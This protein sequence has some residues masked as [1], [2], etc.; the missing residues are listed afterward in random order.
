VDSSLKN[1]SA[2]QCLHELN[3]F[4]MNDGRLHY[5]KSDISRLFSTMRAQSAGAAAVPC[6]LP[7]YPPASCCV[8]GVI[9]QQCCMSRLQASHHQPLLGDR[10]KKRKKEGVLTVFEPA[11]SVI[12]GPCGSTGN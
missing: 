11:R 8:R 9:Q 1:L 7:T 6:Q 4:G 10:K 5:L 12:Y 2:P 3:G